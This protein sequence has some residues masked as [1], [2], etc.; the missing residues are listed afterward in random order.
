MSL[1]INFW[2]LPAATSVAVGHAL[3]FGLVVHGQVMDVEADTA[4]YINGMA[5]SQMEDLRSVQT[6]KISEVQNV[7]PCKSL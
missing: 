2:S 1:S 3:L 4:A 5:A 6:S 7:K